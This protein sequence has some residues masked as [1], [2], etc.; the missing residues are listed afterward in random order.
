MDISINLHSFRNTQSQ[1]N[2]APTA[3]SE[4][5]H[6]PYT[7]ICIPIV[8][9]NPKIGLGLL[10]MAIR[11]RRCDDAAAEIADAKAPGKGVNALIVFGA[12]TVLN[13]GEGPAWEVSTSSFVIP[14]APACKRFSKLTV[15]FRFMGRESIL[16]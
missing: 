10:D 3:C 11:T 1:L 6:C 9:N 8:G 7:N 16:S 4:R 12:H 5:W 2:Y 15:G 13:A 14:K